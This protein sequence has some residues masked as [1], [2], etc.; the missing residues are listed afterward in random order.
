MHKIAVAL[1]LGLAVSCAGSGPGG[2][3]LDTGKAEGADESI[4]HL[5]IAVDFADTRQEPSRDLVPAERDG[6]DVSDTYAQDVTPDEGT[7]GYEVRTGCGDDRD[8]DD[9]NLC[10]TD[11]CG[12]DGECLHT[13]VNCDDNNACT[14]D[15]CDPDRGCI[16]QDK[17]KPKCLAKGVCEAGVGITCKDGEYVCDYADVANYSAKE[18]CDG[19]DNN[20][21]GKTD[22]GF[23]DTDGDQVADCVD[24]DDD[25]DGVPDG[26]DCRPLDPTVPSCKG[27]QCGDDGCGGSC[28]ECD[29]HIACTDD[30]C[31]QGK[32]V[33]RPKPHQPCLDTGVC[34]N[35]KDHLK[36]NE[37]TGQY[38]CDYSDVRDYEP[39]NETSCD[40]LDNDCDG[41]TDEGELCD[42]SLPCTIDECSP[43]LHHCVHTAKSCDDRDPCTVDQCDPKTGKCLH[44]PKTCDDNNACTMDTCDKNTGKCVYTPLGH[45]RFFDPVA[46]QDKAGDQDEDNIF[47]TSAARIWAQMKGLADKYAIQ[48]GGEPDFSVYSGSYHIFYP[49]LQPFPH[50]YGQCLHLGTTTSQAAWA[51]RDLAKPIT[52]DVLVEFEYYYPDPDEQDGFIVFASY[53]GSAYTFVRITQKGESISTQDHANVRNIIPGKWHHFAIRATQ[54]TYKLYI[55]GSLATSG[56]LMSDP[57]IYAMGYIGD[58]SGKVHNGQGYFDNFRVSRGIDVLFHDYLNNGDSAWRFYGDHE[59]SDKLSHDEKGLSDYPYWTGISRAIQQRIETVSFAYL[60]TGD[61]R[62]ADWVKPVLMSLCTTG[63]STWGDPDY[64]TGKPVLDGAHFT[65]GVSEAFDNIADTLTQGEKD[66][67][68]DCIMQRGIRPIYQEA[69]SPPMNDPGA[70]P[71][72]FALHHAAMGIGALALW[73]DRD[74]A[75]YLDEARQGMDRMYR[76]A[77]KDGGWIEGITYGSY[78]MTNALLFG[79]FDRV[80]TGHNVFNDPYVRNISR[81]L[82]H[83][84]VPAG[85][86]YV[87]FADSSSSNRNY[88]TV[89]PI[90]YDRTGDKYAMKLLQSVGW[91]VEYP[92]AL[93]LF[94]PIK[95]SQL[96]DL[97][98]E[99]TGRD[100]RTI[101]WASM[102]TSWS[103]DA[104]MVATHA[105]PEVG[106]SHLDENTVVIAKGGTWFAHDPGYEVYQAGPAHDF[107]YGTIGHNTLMVGNNFQ[108]KSVT[109]SLGEIMGFY[110][111]KDMGVSIGSAGAAYQDLDYFVRKLFLDKAG[112]CL[113]MA[114]FY[115]KAAGVT[116]PVRFILHPQCTNYTVDQTSHMT[117]VTKGSDTMHL[118]TLQP[119]KPQIEITDDAFGMIGNTNFYL[120]VPE[121]QKGHGFSVTV[122]YSAIVPLSISQYD[123]KAYHTVA[124]LP[125]DGTD[126]EVTFD[127]W[128][129]LYD[130]GTS[131]TGINVLFNFSGGLHVYAISARDKNTGDT[132]KVTAG[133]PDDNKVSAHTP[134]VCFYPA[135][136]DPPA[137][138]HGKWA[139][140][141]HS[142]VMIDV[143]DS[144]NPR[145]AR[146]LNALCTNPDSRPVY[147]ES[148]TRDNMLIMRNDQVVSLVSADKHRQNIDIFHV[149]ADYSCNAQGQGCAGPDTAGVAFTGQWTRAAMDGRFF[150]RENQST[151]AGL[152]IALDE[153]LP[154]VIKVG[155]IYR[156]DQAGFLVL[157]DNSGNRNIAR[158]PASDTYRAITVSV[159]VKPGHPLDLQRLELRPSIPM[160]CAYILVEKMANSD[161]CDVGVSGDTDTNAHS[162]GISVY[163]AEWSAPTRANGLSAR[164]STGDANFYLNINDT[165]S[166]HLIRITYSA[167]KDLQVRQWMGKDKGYKAVGDLIGDN[168]IHTTVIPVIR[169]YVDYQGAG[170]NSATNVLFDFSGPITVYDLFTQ[171]Q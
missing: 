5:D 59:L 167:P 132:Y 57:A 66:L 149:R 128:K 105:G 88:G 97:S 77:D 39:G 117:T 90:L 145:E 156:S 151:A 123:G 116:D 125:G 53:S 11:H 37:T 142:T 160:K 102:R 85:T 81:F 60:V 36:C 101:G 76:G 157:H 126:R 58:V 115:K 159:K 3:G 138:Y 170:A 162:P 124:M 120:N 166:F 15:K 95:E 33:F 69:Q 153:P 150:V 112:E 4:Q 86:Q 28:G 34:N 52:G 30:S 104:L 48:D 141:R 1:V 158:L 96:P 103:K 73:C 41:K 42:D 79:L 106:H 25:N 93:S 44:R 171:G 99:N 111:D 98:N 87:N 113:F 89:L 14:L 22:E 16:H 50:G 17:Q 68:E 6:A 137:K 165:D 35:G 139:R 70:W 74:V 118:W 2:G 13:P 80:V 168:T 9:H 136:W 7:T 122:S 152:T 29:D 49:Y 169:N 119:R 144:Q 21:N 84:L 82:Y 38:Y 110:S 56:Q 18:I 45:P 114:D 31:V 64:G 91:H 12:R 72:G 63:W 146:F 65:M 163:P 133:D 147:F 100:F 62:Y 109:N 8:C 24:P 71:N 140:G 129:P 32:C 161:L 131:T 154:K 75:K 134:G 94:H 78:A 26:K 51:I 83:N 67:I 164:T 148:D 43:T 55:D 92:L 47:H 155:L 121:A 108:E 107:T 27:K 54:G 130:Y 20:C 10:T 19:L 61:T 23:P 46:L 135:E 40:G 143:R 127:V